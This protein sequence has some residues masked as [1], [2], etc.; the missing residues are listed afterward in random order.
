MLTRIEKQF[1]IIFAIVVSADL[2]MSHVEG[3]EPYRSISKPAIVALL[4]I[5]F[6]NRG[7]HLTFPIRLTTL[8]ALL[9]SLLG[10]ILLLYEAHQSNF[11]MFGLVA[12]L[13]AHVMYIIVFL[14]DRNSAIKP[15]GFI[16]LLLVYAIGL[17][18][19]LMDHLGDL[20]M[21]VIIYM[22]IILTMATSAYLRKNKVP[23]ISFVLV[24]VGALLFMVSDSILALNKFYQAIPFSSIYIMGTYALAQLCLV[25]GILRS[26]PKS[27]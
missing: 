5:F 8:L 18:Y 2:V 12:F 10:D 20:F 1:C 6:Y 24:F 14:K 22:V 17:C 16:G 13:I 23:R 11:F 15:F 4:I 19:L 26:A 7:K 3:L 21:P 25:L 27:R 9:F